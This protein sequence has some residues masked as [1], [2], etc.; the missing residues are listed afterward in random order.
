MSVSAA[1]ELASTRHPLERR[2]A[3][4]PQEPVPSDSDSDGALDAQVTLL[5]VTREAAL[6]HD[7][8]SRR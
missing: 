6:A 1:T 5:Q 7:V 3:Q 8:V 4:S 2:S